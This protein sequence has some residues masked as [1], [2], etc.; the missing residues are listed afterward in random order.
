MPN[1][2]QKLDS[3]L[4]RGPGVF[5]VA[6]PLLIFI[7]L[8]LRN[9]AT[10]PLVVDEYLYSK[11]SRLTPLSEAYYPNYLY[12]LIY[13][14][15]NLCGDGFLGCAHFLNCAFY[16]AGF[17]PI[18]AI[19]RPMTGSKMALW[20]A[21]LAVLAPFNYFT[22]FFMI[23]APY[24]FAF[25]LFVWWLMQLQPQSSALSWFLTGLFL[26]GL[27]LV[28]VNG[29]FILPAII[30]Y[31]FYL[32][33]KAPHFQL[34]S[35]L[36]NCVGLILGLVLVK[37]GMGWL[38]AG[39]GGLSIGGLYT[40][41]IGLIGEGLIKGADPG[42][43]APGGPFNLSLIAGLWSMFS[44]LV[45]NAIQFLEILMMNVLPITFIFAPALA[46]VCFLFSQKK[47]HSK[48][49]I[50]SVEQFTFLGIGILINL[51]LF[52]TAFTWVAV[53]FGGE[54]AYA[55]RRYYEF[56]F[57]FFLIWVGI[58]LIGDAE[59]NTLR[60]RL[61]IGFLIAVG[62]ADIIFFNQGTYWFADWF[63]TLPSVFIVWALLL[64]VALVLWVKWPAIG[65]QY[66][67]VILMPVVV[68]ATNFGIF[69]TI[70]LSRIVP[71]DDLKA[72]LFVRQQLSQEELSRLVVASAKP[73]LMALFY[74]DNPQIPLQTI[75][76]G[77]D[78][79]KAQLPIGKD[80]LLLMGDSQLAPDMLNQTYMNY[81]S[82]GYA[83]LFGGHGKYSVDFKKAEWPNLI[84]KQSG[85]FNPPES[86]GAWTT[87]DK[88][89]LQ[90]IK[91]L[92][93]KFNLILNARAFGPNIGERFFIQVGNEQ[94]PIVLGGV[95][96]K[97][98][99]LINNTL[100]VSTISISIPKPSSPKLLGLGDDE[101]KLGMALTN[102]EIEW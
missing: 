40:N 87:S 96:E 69:Q 8:F 81:V 53:N 83:T 73:N 100:K 89:V 90:F 9:N 77:S 67:L 28:K 52:A 26:G 102:L 18:Y 11:F 74:L 22:A 88:L 65:N 36:A 82:L 54:S 76:Y 80:W 2:A 71:N 79:S 10:Y 7:F 50:S 46:T 57:P 60:N 4:L 17:I 14:S 62:M 98:M 25:W 5:L 85:L 91:P 32:G 95:F 37:W 59:K 30:A 35:L 47:A 86:W 27:A 6:I 97:Q 93:Q 63:A 42:E 12:Y 24:F 49:G 66:F 64:T 101:R 61:I 33:S 94:I 51:I 1:G 21:S 3:P 55:H 56:A 41:N 19:A 29:L 34:K 78:Y 13:R 99:I 20:I 75:S 68:M 92:P 48:E 70:Q 45:R 43:V 84:E 38:V 31:L 15:T 23:E 72:S 16:A 39:S 58:P 44:G